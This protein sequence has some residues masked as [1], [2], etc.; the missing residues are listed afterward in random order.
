MKNDV[1]RFYQEK[2][3]KASKEA[4][5]LKKK[6]TRI[7]LIRLVYF[8]TWIATIIVL[9][10]WNIYISILL[11]Y[12]GIVGFSRLLKFHERLQKALAIDQRI[13]KI[14]KEE[15]EIFHHH[16]QE[17]DGGED[18]ETE[19]HPYA[20]DMDIFGKGSLFAYINRC[21]TSLG[22]QQL[23]HFFLHPVQKGII[24]HRQK[25][26][27][28]LEQN[29]EWCLHF[30]AEGYDIKDS[31]EHIDTLHL[32]LN[33]PNLVLGNKIYFYLSILL[34]VFT[35]GAFIGL[36][37]YFSFLIS[38]VA[39]LPASYLLSKAKPKVDVIQNYVNRSGEIL[40]AYS[41]MMKH[42]EASHFEAPLLLKH[43][44]AFQGKTLASK[45]IKQLSGQIDNL[46]VRYNV[47]GI[48]LNVFTL[49]DLH[50]A[51]KLEQ[52]KVEHHTLL[53]DWFEGLA[54]IEALQSIATLGF[55]HP[56]WC[57]PLIEGSSISALQVG[58]PLIDP[59]KRVSNDFQ[60][61]S[62]HH[63]YLVT[64]SNM[65]GK[66]TFLRTIGTQIILTYMGS[67]VCAKSWTMPDGI[68]LF[69]S[70]RTQDALQ[71]STSGFYA[72]LKRL[73]TLIK[74]VSKGEH[75]FFL[76]DEILK[77][78]NSVDRNKGA[79]ALMRQL[80]NYP[81]AGLISTHDLTLGKMAEELKGKI[82][83][84]CFE[85]NVEGDELSFD[86]TLRQ[87][88]SQSFNATQLMRKIGIKGL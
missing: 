24:E 2:A 26:N 64:G 59:K 17:R 63:I 11:F 52:W 23:A 76:L 79:A 10:Q 50:W 33:S 70:M 38:L 49:W 61:P 82:S 55:H 75:I 46:N 57:V 32:W 47:F 29:P 56:E 5:G 1:S 68:S 84:I 28:E 21:K 58:H 69:S 87:G 73:E 12:V 83:N 66:S 37:Y 22:R 74:R 9:F 60:S 25:A 65:G 53:P 80:I 8:L 85:V 44:Q 3:E 34:P 86:Y 72:E 41:D 15:I 31:R 54:H 78:T 20:L 45:S 27:L 62:E 30:Q 36:W 71:E 14:C 35:L 48:I 7:S 51:R 40:S 16:F 43:L 4:E 6:S 67:R 39:L 18:L 77:G 19:G 81:S 13:E 42:L 88:V